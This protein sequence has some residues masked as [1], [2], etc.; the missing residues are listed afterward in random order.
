MVMTM[1]AMMMITFERGPQEVSGD[2]LSREEEMMMIV[3]IIMFK[4]ILI[5]GLS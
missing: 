3:M 1:F 4:I 5:P 2:H